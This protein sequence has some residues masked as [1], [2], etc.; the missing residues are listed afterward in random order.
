MT[1]SLFVLLFSLLLAAPTF[2]DNQW[3]AIKKKLDSSL[4]R[5]TMLVLPSLPATG[6]RRRIVSGWTLR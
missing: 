5:I 6:S 4:A 1:R 3:T 2:A